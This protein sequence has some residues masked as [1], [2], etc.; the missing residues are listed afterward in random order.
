MIKQVARDELQ[1]CL[2]VIHTSFQTVAKEFGLTME[3]CPGHTS[4]MP[5]E[6]LEREFD[7]GNLMFAYVKDDEYIGFFSLRK[8]DETSCE[9]HQLAVLPQYRH[10]GIGRALVEY[11][12]HV[13]A[14]ILHMKKIKIGII[15]ESRVLKTWYEQLGF[16]QT[17]MHKF[18]HLPF[19]VGFLELS[20]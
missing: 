6:R 10:L 2:E 18:D 4:F 5:L 12:K 13:A 16:V 11:A 15:D 7:W 8:T 1:I 20:I 14:D 9:L 17:G 19:T 3:N